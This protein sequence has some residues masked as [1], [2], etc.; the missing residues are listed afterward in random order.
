M[1]TEEIF[2]L[3]E[4]DKEIRKKFMGMYPIDLILNNLPVPCLIVVNLDSSEK[5]GSHWIVHYPK[6]HVKYF[7]TLGKRQ[8]KAIHLL[9]NS[10]GITYKYN[11]TRLQSSN[12]ETCGLFCFHY[13]YY[14]CRKIEFNFILTNFSNNLYVIHT[15]SM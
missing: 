11:K 12:T 8:V 1:N 6:N 4:R 7:D 10:K 2:N 5:K 9:L 14:S 13:S 15:T 3:M